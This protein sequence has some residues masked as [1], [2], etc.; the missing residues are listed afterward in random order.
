[1]GFYNS[2]RI[3]LDNLVLN[4]DAGNTKSYVGDIETP[5]GPAYGYIADA[6]DVSLL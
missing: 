5:A 2:P 1:M 6:V 4:L 3:I